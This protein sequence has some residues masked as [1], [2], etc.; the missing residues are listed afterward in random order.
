METDMSE[1][2][3]FVDDEPNILLAI[4]RQ[5][6]K[7][8]ELDIATS[9][10][11]GLEKIKN[12]GPFAV[13]VSDFRM[14]EMDGVQFLTKVREIE[15]D[16]VRMML[17]GFADVKVTIN[18]VNEGKIFR[19]LT[20]PCPSETLISALNNGLQQYRLIKAE[21]ELLEQT[22]KGSIKVLTEILGL[23][24]PEV[25]GKSARIKRLV[26]SIAKIMKLERIWQLETAAM[27]SQIGCIILSENTL[28]RINSGQ[29]LTSNEKQLFEKH[30]SVAANLISNIPRMKKIALIVANQHKNYDGSGTPN[31]S[32]KGQAIPM[33]ARILKV[34]H[35]FD[36]LE[37][38][39]FF[40]EDA[41][42]KMEIQNGL[43]DPSVLESLRKFVFEENLQENCKHV[44]IVE[45]KENMIFD[46]DVKTHT[47]ILLVSRGQEV[48]AAMIE[49]LKNYS[50]TTGIKEP[51]LVLVPKTTF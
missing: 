15:A 32:L 13:V 2:I 3:L 12:N 24:N 7:K 40:K 21:K 38:R 39:G 50:Q 20:K 27:L 36:I 11:E 22:L 8:Y 37:S 4:Q 6:R 28:K 25:F 5:L 16:T 34:A 42:R 29:Q 18:A 49:R 44:R 35:D 26:K 14:P 33:G 23:I 19:F 41:I 43:Y 9:P 30:V 17:T 48:S 31:N 51:I 45:L 10:M 46:E 1:K 47:G